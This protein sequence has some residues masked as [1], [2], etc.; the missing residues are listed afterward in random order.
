MANSWHIPESC[1]ILYL[2]KPK[3]ILLTYILAFMMFG[4]NWLCMF[5]F[6]RRTW[7]GRNCILPKTLYKIHAQQNIIHQ[8]YMQKT[9][10]VGQFFFF[11]CQISQSAWRFKYGVMINLIRMT[12]SGFSAKHL[13]SL[14][15]SWMHMKWTFPNAQLYVCVIMQSLIEFCLHSSRALGP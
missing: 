6:M 3:L 12:G 7:L 10:Y 5:D 14:I 8:R 2:V 13:P 1:H 4:E 9:D 15:L 11:F